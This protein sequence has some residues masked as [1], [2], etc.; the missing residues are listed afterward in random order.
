MAG[1]RSVTGEIYYTSLITSL[2]LSWAAVG[3]L[4][5]TLPRRRLL[6]AIC[7]AAL[8]LS[9]TFMDYSTSGLENPLVH[10]LLVLFLWAWWRISDPPSPNAV[11]TLA[12]LA[13]AILLCRLDLVF[14]VAPVLTAMLRHRHDAVAWRRLV[15]GFAPLIAWEVFSITYY[16]MFLPNTAY[17]KLGA[18]FPTSE[19]LERGWTYLGASASFDP[20][21]ATLILAGLAVAAVRRRA[22]EIVAGVGILLYLGYVVRIG[23]DFM[24]GRFL[25]APLIVAVALIL[26]LPEPRPL[27]AG[28]VAAMV[29]ILAFLAPHPVMTTGPDFAPTLEEAVG[30]QGVA[31][32][33]AVYFQATGLLRTD[34][35]DHAVDYSWARQGRQAR[36]R[37]MMVAPRRTTGFFGYFAGPDVHVVDRFGLSDPLL[38]RL[39]VTADKNWR[40]GHLE[41]EIPAGYLESA[42]SASTRIHDP[43]IAELDALL[44]TVTRGPLFTADRWRAIMALQ[45]AK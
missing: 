24:A 20:L 2:L 21:A 5:A 19:Y 45:F 25:T 27:V 41:R 33:R 15:L 12:L 3:L 34:R 23:G 35:G 32:E 4:V 16:G 36:V 18:G 38:A 42:R 44:R 37:G 39:P 7:V 26:R 30:D 40:V 22:P 29:V 28:T 6:A 1:T 9:R 17:A 31:D 10:L 8:A 13:S 11:F 14:I 43:A